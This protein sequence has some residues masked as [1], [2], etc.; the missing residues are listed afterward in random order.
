MRVVFDAYWW[1]EGPLSNQMVQRRLIEAWLADHPEDTGVLVV[2]RA[3]LAAARADAP[4]GV[5]VVGTAARPHAVAAATVLGE[6]ARRRRADV[7][8]AHNFTP[9]TGAAVTF[10]HDVL[11]VTN[12][13]WFTPAERLYL[14]P[15]PLLARRAGAVATSSAHEAERIR[16]ATRGLQLVRPVGLAV[17][18]ELTAAAPAR[19]AALGGVEDFLLTVSRLNVRKNLDRLIQA[20]LSAGTATPTRPLVVVGEPEGRAADLGAAADTARSQGSLRFLDRVDDAQLAWLYGHTSL[21]CYPS[22][23]EGFG[24]PPVEA[25]AFGARILASDIPVFRETLRERATYVDP[26]DPE[27]M[28][29]ALSSLLGSGPARQAPVEDRS[30][31]QCAGALRDLAIEVVA[32]RGSPTPR[33]IGRAP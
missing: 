6:L 32:A 11:F 1:V 3:H 14:W 26:K 2:P 29:A 31:S 13:E 27:A 28:A 22:L 12:P 16:T 8:V 20:A 4:N 33:R 30:W 19:P 18:P 17:N 10:V 9:V 23:D 24:L 21:F 25:L 7:V 5:E 15:I